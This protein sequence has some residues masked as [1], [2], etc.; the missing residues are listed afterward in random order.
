MN[1]GGVSFF[2]IVF[3]AL[4]LRIFERRVGMSIGLASAI[5]LTLMVDIWWGALLGLLLAVSLLWRGQYHRLPSAEQT[6][7]ASACP[8]DNAGLLRSPLLRPASITPILDRFES[9]HSLGREAQLI[10]AGVLWHL[11]GDRHGARGHCLDLL[12]KMQPE[13][14]LFTQVCDLFFSTCQTPADRTVRT[15]VPLSVDAFDAMP[16]MPVTDSGAKI[17]PFKSRDAGAAPLH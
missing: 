4:R 11:Y 2:S 3:E 7:K 6:D 5:V 13:D 12:G 10:K 16:S 1:F 8:N 14:P 15:G 9:R 17:I